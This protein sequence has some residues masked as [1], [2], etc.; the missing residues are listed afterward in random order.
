LEN[1]C[2]GLVFKLRANVF[3]ARAHRYARAEQLPK[4]VMAAFPHPDP[5]RPELQQ[6]CREEYERNRV[7]AAYEGL[8]RRKYER[9]AARPWLPVEPDPPEPK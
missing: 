3:R 6:V 2:G 8:M 7:F 1:R 9:A 5:R 4:D